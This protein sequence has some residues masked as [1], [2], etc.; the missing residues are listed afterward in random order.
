MSI[1][2]FATNP[3]VAFSQYICIVLTILNLLWNSWDVAFTQASSLKQCFLL[4]NVKMGDVM[5]HG[6]F[7]AEVKVNVG[8]SN[9][10]GVVLWRRHQAWRG[11]AMLWMMWVVEQEVQ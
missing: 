6:L 5:G 7:Q 2:I 11:G 10:D 8:L 1:R 4:D 9:H 3:S